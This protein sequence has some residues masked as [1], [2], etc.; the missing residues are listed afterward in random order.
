MSDL[1]TKEL[2]ESV[3][4][5]A[6]QAGEAIKVV[7]DQADPVTVHTKSDDSPVT[8]AD[9]AAHHVIV[10]KLTALTPDIPVFSEESENVSYAE[11]K[12]W[13][14]YWLVDPLDGTKEFIN[15]TGEFTV[16]IALIEDHEPVL[17]VVTVPL[18][19]QAY[20]G[21]QGVGA[22]KVDAGTWRKISV[23]TVENRQLV[24]VGSRRHGAEKLN[25]LLAKL[26]AAGYQTDMTSMGSSLKFCLIAEGKADLYPRLA[27]TSEWDTAAAQAV[28]MEAGGRV[29]N[30]E[31]DP[32]T[33]NREESVLNPEFYALGDPAIEW[34]TLL[35]S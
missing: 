33:Y 24:V 23:R 20:L 8:A 16:N 34:E 21:G 7:Y 22:F 17:G 4:A 10:D 35:K 29:I 19:N 9:H 26:E 11:R 6:E 5:I 32:L 1:V 18:K 27:P 31:F 15:G 3:L 2:M 28:L 12:T 14:R 13:P 25:A 30:T